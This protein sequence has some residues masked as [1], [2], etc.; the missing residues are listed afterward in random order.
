MV[1][2]PKTIEEL[3]ISPKER[4][5]SA[6]LKRGSMA[7]VKFDLDKIAIA[8]QKASVAAGRSYSD[9][10]S[11]EFATTVQEGLSSNGKLFAHSGRRIPE[12]RDVEEAVLNNF[13][14]KNIRHITEAI[15]QGLGLPYENVERIVE[16]IIPDI[17]PTGEF[18]KEYMAS[19]KQVREK[20]VHL[21]FAIE[22]DSTDKQLLIEDAHN[23][24]PHPFN[25][26]ALANLILERTNVPYADTIRA[27]KRTQEILALRKTDRPIQTEEIISITDLSLNELGYSQNNLLG[28][29]RINISLDDVT[30]LIFN[31]SLENSNIQSNNP[32]AV[33]LGIAELVLKQYALNERI[34]DLDVAE[35][36]KNGI[37]HLH[38]L[39]YPIRTYCS[40]HSIE[41]L[42]Q[43]GL[44]VVV[45]NLDAKS[46]PATKPRVLNNHLHTFL[47]AIQSSYAGALGFPMLNTLYAPVLLKEVEMVEGEEIIGDSDG[48][49]IKVPRRLEREVLEDLISDQNIKEFRETKSTRILK[50]RRREELEEISQNL[51]FGAS[52]SA[53]SRGGQTL[54]IDF[55][56]DL[57]TPDHVVNVPALFGKNQYIMSRQNERGEWEVVERTSE[58]PRRVEGLMSQIKG[59]EHEPDKTN[60]DVIQPE[61]D[62]VIMTYGHELVQ[63]ASREFTYA[64]LKIFEDGDKYGN[65]FNFP[66]CDVHVGR[67]TFE[68]PEN[69]KLLRRA[70]EVVE[71]N[72]AVY[73]MFDRGDGMNVAQCC[74]LRERITD[75]E[76]LKHP[77]KMRFCGFQNV[78]INLAQAAYKSSG[79]SLEERLNSTINEIDNALLLA[80]KAHVNKREYVQKLLDTDGT[81]LRAMGVPSDDGEPYIDLKKATYIFGVVG[82]NELVQSLTGKQLHEDAEAFKVG[83]KV[84]SHMYEIKNQFT[85]RYGLKFVIEETPGESAN[86]R[87]AKIDQMQF[88]EQSAR[89]LKGSVEEDE[90]YYTNSGHLWAQAPVSGIDRAILQAKTN[91]L[92]EA[93][94]ITHLFT[95]EKKNRAS[96]V[97]DFVKSM[98]E[99]TQSSQVVFSG[100]HTVCL[101]CGNHV[102]GLVEKCGA[103][104]NDVPEKIAQKTRIVGYE[105]DV[106]KWNKSKKGELKARQKAQ[107]FYAGQQNSIIDLEADL[108]ESIIEKENIRVGIIGSP[109]CPQCDRAYR[110]IERALEKVPEE[111]RN[112]IEI[113]K[114]DVHNID[115]RVTAMIYNAPLDTFP[116]VVVHKGDTFERFSS[117]YPYSGKPRTLT[118]PIFQQMFDRIVEGD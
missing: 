72:D 9:K 41:F 15:S 53:F 66:K 78:S 21:P 46:K 26:D 71:H 14:Q 25:A 16:K 70:C 13:D 116:T 48:N 18:Y 85:E 99:N 75:P 40:A 91:P 17:D 111:T 60:G 115:D 100:E 82:L 54:F 76:I 73:F 34:F 105:S 30:Q 51:I 42:K 31:R 4:E 10:E 80:L 102:R 113:V 107:E 89:V 43:Y 1:K 97:F 3:L 77:E 55:N 114:Y 35:A 63:K 92:I 38:D 69:E 27:V 87:L 33:N 28:G 88:P 2:F 108:L 103:C 118:T 101:S 11:R 84:L 29:R 93:G 81:P 56:I 83:L 106:R 6:V 22:F 7:P 19:R 109:D 61:G 45:A 74:R 24:K 90:V 98:Y 68:N 57:G 86:R 23:G 32:E 59:H 58:E 67:D 37:I 12:V 36:H 110:I 8:V 112:Q 52:Q 104:G 64:L 49:R 79:D 50:L 95:G 65:L 62:E 5:I 44:D 39:G 20:L 117:E 47:A 96:S 94:A